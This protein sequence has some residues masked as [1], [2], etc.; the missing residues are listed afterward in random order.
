VQGPQNAF[1]EV[2]PKTTGLFLK[3]ADKRRGHS[4]S[5][6]LV[7]PRLCPQTAFAWQLFEVIY[8]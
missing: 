6:V 3:Q 1:V 4:L 7:T 5:A 8:Y 2:R